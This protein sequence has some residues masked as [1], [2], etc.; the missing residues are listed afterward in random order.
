MA[1][2]CGGMFSWSGDGRAAVAADGAAVAM[3]LAASRPADSEPR[4]ASGKFKA[5][6]RLADSSDCWCRDG[7][8]AGRS[9]SAGG[10][11]GSLL[12]AKIPSTSPLSFA[13]AA[14]HSQAGSIMAKCSIPVIY[15]TRR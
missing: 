7:C 12:V 2:L 14:R 6:V 13:P 5:S 8:G 9:K 15:T 11:E 3:S 10:G 1:L 4:D